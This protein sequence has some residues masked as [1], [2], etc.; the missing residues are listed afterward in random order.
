[1]IPTKLVKLNAEELEFLFRELPDDDTDGATR[2]MIVLQ[3]LTD[4]ETS[5]VSLP[6]ILLQR[7]YEAAAIDGA[8]ADWLKAIFGRTLGPELDGR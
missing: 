4:E 3:E 6:P 2:F 8:F 5:E 7:L 1:M